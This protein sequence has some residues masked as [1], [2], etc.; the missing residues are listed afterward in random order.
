MLFQKQDKTVYA[1]VSL[2][3]VLISTFPVVV[4]VLVLFGNPTS[5]VAKYV[6]ADLASEREK[7]LRPGAM[8]MFDPT[9]QEKACLCESQITKQNHVNTWRF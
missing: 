3:V 9:L 5:H 2:K 8:M 7:T 1:A 6:L 4:L